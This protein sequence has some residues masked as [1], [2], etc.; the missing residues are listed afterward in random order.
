M[1][2][3]YARYSSMNAGKS[4]Q[5][6]QVAN[7][8]KERGMRA[9]IM[10]PI[11]DTRMGAYVHSRLG[12]KK[13]PDLLIN[14]EMDIEIVMKNELLLPHLIECI[15]V[16]EAQFLTKEQVW[17]LTQIAD[18]Y[19]VPIIA[20]FI[21]TDFQGNLFEGSMALLQWADEIEEL[22]TICWCGRKATMVLR[23]DEYGNV[24]LKGKQVEIG[25]ND[26]YTSVCRR[27]WKEKKTKR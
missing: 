26:K 12:I 8:Y 3:L 19:N 27:H 14:K 11:V 5:L 9:Y 25:G 4:T 2:K 13:Y 7:N 15:L 6:L 22:K 21:R 23:T 18:F 24:V 1:A 16:D 17:Q 10:K 20:Y